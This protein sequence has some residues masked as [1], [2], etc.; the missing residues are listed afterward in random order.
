MLRERE[1]EGREGGGREGGGREKERKRER[2]RAVDWCSL[3]HI[4]CGFVHFPARIYVRTFSK[5][6]A[7]IVLSFGG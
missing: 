5:D 4:R 7:Y 6:R 2:E 1:R 3:L